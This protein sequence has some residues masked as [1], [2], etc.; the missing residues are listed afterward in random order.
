MDLNDKYARKSAEY[1]ICNKP[2][3]YVARERILKSKMV[4]IN[5][6]DEI[7]NGQSEVITE[8]EDFWNDYYMVFCYDINGEVDF[9][10][11]EDDFDSYAEAK[12]RCDELNSKEA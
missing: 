8:N 1:R 12:A 7:P 11:T 10:S 6:E 9:D 3:W 4:V 5:S 2:K